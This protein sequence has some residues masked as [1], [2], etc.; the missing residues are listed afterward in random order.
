MNVAS[1][2]GFPLPSYHK[3]RKVSIAR[4]R[5]ADPRL[6]QAE[7]DGARTLRFS[8]VNY[9]R[10]AAASSRRQLRARCEWCFAWFEHTRATARPT[11]RRNSRPSCLD[12]SRMVSDGAVRPLAAP[13]AWEQRRTADRPSFL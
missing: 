9:R 7:R 13:K 5:R 1:A 6:W 8:G 10:R 4:H 2:A 11:W 3:A 12:D